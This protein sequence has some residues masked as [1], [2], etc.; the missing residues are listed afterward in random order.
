MRLVPK[1]C[2]IHIAPARFDPKAAVFLPLP[3]GLGVLPNVFHRESS[4]LP[5]G[6]KP[7]ELQNFFCWL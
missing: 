5:F 7:H 4:L 1:A 2:Q 6:E 3:R